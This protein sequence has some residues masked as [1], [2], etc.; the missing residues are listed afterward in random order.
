MS[1]SFLRPPALT[2]SF[3]VHSLPL[4]AL[5]VPFYANIDR[6][7]RTRLRECDGTSCS[8][9][10]SLRLTMSSLVFPVPS[11]CPSLYA[12]VDRKMGTRMG[13]CHGLVCN[14]SFAFPAADH[15]VIFVFP[16]L[17]LVRFVSVLKLKTSARPAQEYSD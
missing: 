14:Y 13:G 17:F 15:L 2:I 3:L 9:L 10:R 7:M 8:F 12:N 1:C 5:C 6:K 4:C 16:L 11:L